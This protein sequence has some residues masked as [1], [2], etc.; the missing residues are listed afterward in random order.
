MKKTSLLLLVFLASAAIADNWIENSDDDLPTL[1]ALEA[2][3]GDKSPL[4]SLPSDLVTVPVISPGEYHVPPRIEDLRDSKY[5]DMVNYG[6]NIF[7][8]TKQYARRYAGNGLNCSS[9]HLQEG[10]K[11]FAAPLWAAFPLYPA[12]REKTKQVM[13][14]Q[15]RLQ[16]CFRFSLD[17]MA[18][19]LDTPEIEALTVYAQWLSTGIPEGTI[20]P[21]RGFARIDKTHDP[22][23][24][25]GEVIYKQYCALCHGDD[26][27]GKKH[28][29]H[30][31]YMFPPLAGPDTY[32]KGAGLHKVK[33]CAGFVQ[34][35]MPPGRPFLL[36]D[37]ESLEVCV[38]IYLQD[39]PWNPRKSWFTNM[40]MQS[41]ES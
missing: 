35:N 7:I 4:L 12:Y 10:R 25:N 40:F 39:R 9:C 14:F 8:D 23:A 19:A 21:G 20:M 28:V 37:D 41:M 26:L 18:P 17:G 36:S 11:P 2:R 15:E 33:T 29:R 34:A 38:H 31:G 13:T 24:F 22:S 32:N 3:H 16:D 27:L 6:R 30:E 1:D 5:A